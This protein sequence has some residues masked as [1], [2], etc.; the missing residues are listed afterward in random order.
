MVIFDCLLLISRDSRL[1]FAIK[2]FILGSTQH[3]DIQMVH[4]FSRAL[5]D[6][7]QNVKPL[8]TQYLDGPTSVKASHFV[9][10]DIM[11]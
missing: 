11:F 1:P 6:A 10:T 3:H 2:F 5:T 4:F 7:M 9:Y 8:I